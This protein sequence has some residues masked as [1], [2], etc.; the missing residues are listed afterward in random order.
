MPHTFYFHIH[1]DYRSGPHCR[2]VSENDL[3]PEDD[4][5][6]DVFMIDELPRVHDCGVYLLTQDAKEY[7][8]HCNLITETDDYNRAKEITE[9]LYSKINGCTPFKATGWNSAYKEQGSYGDAIEITDPNVSGLSLENVS[10]DGPILAL[11]I[12]HDGE[13]MSHLCIS[14]MA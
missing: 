7:E 8:F 5:M 11:V 3:D 6:W 2:I 10:S 9:Q 14:P 1:D 13:L 12:W 4:T